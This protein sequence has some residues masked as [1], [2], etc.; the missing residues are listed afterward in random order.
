MSSM[1]ADSA[2]TAAAPKGFFARLK[3][4]LSGTGSS[5][6]RDLKTLV[7]VR[8]ID[9]GVM[10]D[11]EARLLQADVG[12]A[13]TARILEQLQRSVARKELDHVDALLAALRRLLLEILA[14]CQQPLQ[15]DRSA[16]PFVVLVV[17][18]I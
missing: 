3:Q 4:R 6:A 18:G 2:A 7:G 8:A 11:L 10:E 1:P 12:A 5:L 15:V 17:G 14:P 9:V 16:R 13:A